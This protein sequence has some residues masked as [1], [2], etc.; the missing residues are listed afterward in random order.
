MLLRSSHPGLGPCSKGDRSALP[1]HHALCTPRTP[2]Q[3]NPRVQLQPMQQHARQGASSRAS[4]PAK[5][6]DLLTVPSSLLI[7]LPCRRA[8][9]RNSLSVFIC[10]LFSGYLTLSQLQLAAAQ[11]GF[12][13]QHFYGILSVAEIIYQPQ[14]ALHR[15]TAGLDW[16][17][18]SPGRGQHQVLHRQPQRIVEVS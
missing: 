15:A 8:P 4:C 13:S 6:S 5:R 7:G 9:G 16:S 10:C 11:P 2:A 3:R 17:R 18:G 1:L 12:I 14:S